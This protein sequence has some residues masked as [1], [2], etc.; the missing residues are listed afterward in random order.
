VFFSPLATNVVVCTKFGIK[1]EGR[2]TTCNYSPRRRR[3]RGRGKEGGGG[4]EEVQ[5]KRRR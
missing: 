1:K 2:T 3:I 4:K 5:M